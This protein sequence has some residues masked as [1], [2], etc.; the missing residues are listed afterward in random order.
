MFYIYFTTN[1]EKCEQNYGIKPKNHFDQFKYIC[2]WIETGKV[3]RMIYYER[4]V[5]NIY[6]LFAF[7]IS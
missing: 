6:N 1:K 3:Y 4:G 2:V 7:T 5:G